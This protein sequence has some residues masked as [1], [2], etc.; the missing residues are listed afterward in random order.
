MELAGG[1]YAAQ[2]FEFD[3]VGVIVGLDLRY[4][5]ERR[6]WKGFLDESRENVVMRSGEGFDELVKNSYRLLVSRGLKGCYVRF[7]D[8]ETFVRSGIG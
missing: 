5:A 7:M 1:A 4:S 2:G 8:E 6:A 3:Y